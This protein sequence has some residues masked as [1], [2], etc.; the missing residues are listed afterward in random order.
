MRL[1]KLKPDNT[2]LDVA[3]GTGIF[4]GEKSDVLRKADAIYLEKI[5]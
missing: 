2:M 3:C 1:E 5:R 4:T